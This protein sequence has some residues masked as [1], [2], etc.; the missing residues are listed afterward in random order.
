MADR[1]PDFSNKVRS[2]IAEELRGR[3]V[4]LKVDGVTKST[5]R[6]IGIHVQYIKDAKIVVRT[7]GVREMFSRHTA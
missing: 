5:G 1:I 2:S 6:F 3:L 4:C 7:L